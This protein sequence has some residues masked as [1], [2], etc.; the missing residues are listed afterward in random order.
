[1]WI[2]EKKKKIERKIKKLEQKK[3]KNWIDFIIKFDK[4]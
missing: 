1:M 2:I 3:V 4:K